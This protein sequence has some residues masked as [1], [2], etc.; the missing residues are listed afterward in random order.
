MWAQIIWGSAAARPQ[1]KPLKRS[2]YMSEK[3]RKQRVFVSDLDNCDMDQIRRIAV[4]KQSR[5]VLNRAVEALITGKHYTTNLDK[6][7]IY[8]APEWF[9]IR[10]VR[11]WDTGNLYSEEDARKVALA[12]HGVA[13]PVLSEDKSEMVRAAAAYMLYRPDRMIEDSSEIVRSAL[14]FRGYK[15]KVMAEDKAASVRAHAARSKEVPDEILCELGNDKSAV[16]RAAVASR[17]VNLDRFV[18]D[19]S[20][21][22]REVVAE[23]NY[24]LNRLVSDP[25]PL[26]RTKAANAL[27]RKNAEQAN[28]E[29][30]QSEDECVRKALAHMGYHTTILAKD[31][32]PGVRAALAQSGYELDKLLD[33]KDETVRIA[34]ACTG[35]GADRLANDPSVAVRMELAVNAYKPYILCSDQSPAVRATVAI[36]GF[37]LGRLSKDSDER[38]A[39]VAHYAANNDYRKAYV[40]HSNI[41]REECAQNNG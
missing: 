14:A 5:D 4:K 26:V 10:C 19:P 37:E 25:N 40:I 17:G 23:Q 24:G 33:D 2:R 22:V 27:I 34:V 41:F 38:V 39:K 36:H 6:Y 8:D 30:L 28:A 12:L 15:P 16:V 9:Q 32:S 7:V 13:L 11:V 20:P 29:L 1:P 18:T 35:Y 31:P 21:V 3:K